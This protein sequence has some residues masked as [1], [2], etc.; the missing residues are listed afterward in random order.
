MEFKY[1][2]HKAMMEGKPRIREILGEAAAMTGRNHGGFIEAYRTKGADIILL[3]MG[4]VAGTIK[5]A[6]D[7]LRRAGKKI[8]LVKIRC[9]RPFPYEEIWEAIKGTKVVGIMDANFSPGSEGAVGMDLKAKLFGQPNAP[10]VVDF[11]AGLG[12]REIN[13]KT[14][15]K[16]VRR[17]EE[18]KIS[19]GV[20]ADSEWV[21]LNPAILS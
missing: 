6:V 12:G 20:P 17:L 21:D 14:I 4:S 8:G 9:Y 1:A 7:E 19:S 11:I 18:I 5:D 15:A 16:L 2:V 10:R 13:I 3:A